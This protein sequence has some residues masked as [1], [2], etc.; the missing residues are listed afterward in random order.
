MVIEMSA[1]PNINEFYT[2]VTRIQKARAKG[3][4]FEA[5]GTLGR[6]HYYKPRTRSLPIIKPLLVVALLTIGLKGVIHHKIGADLY[7]TRVQALEEKGGFNRL[8][9]YLMSV[10]PASEAVS[11]FLTRHFPTSL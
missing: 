4:G 10:D 9:A 2:R 11:T 1:D 8:G 7:S 3:Y 5:A 6:S